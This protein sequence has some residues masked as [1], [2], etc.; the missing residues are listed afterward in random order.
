[1]RIM[2]WNM[3]RNT[4]FG[5]VH[6]DAWRFVLGHADVALLQETVPPSWVEG[7]CEVAAVQAWPTKPWCTAIIT[8]R[9]CP[10]SPMQLQVEGGRVLAGTADLDDGPLT[11]V[12]IHA[13]LIPPENRVVPALERTFRALEPHLKDR[14]FVVGGDLNSTRVA[15]ERAWPGYGHQGLF[16]TLDESGYF[17]CYWSLHHR[18]EPTMF[19]SRH[20]EGMQADHLFVDSTTGQADGVSSCEVMNADGVQSLSDHRPLV[21][22][23]VPV[24]TSA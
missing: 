1:M 14:A 21:A 4:G 8:P 12:S 3:G 6:D 18:E 10:L 5:T 23:L 11:L 7:E 17:D 16:E 13:R 15:A 24:G 9:G 22:R 19:H 2:T 20:P